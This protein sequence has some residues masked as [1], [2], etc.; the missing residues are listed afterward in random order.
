M[1]FTKSNLTVASA[2]KVQ[3]EKHQ[4]NNRWAVRVVC[5]MDGKAK[6]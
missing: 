1:T 5:S 6:A 4:R 2:R 3:G